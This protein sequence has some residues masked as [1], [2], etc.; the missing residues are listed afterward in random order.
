MRP[1]PHPVPNDTARTQPA[2]LGPGDVLTRLR[3]HARGP[4][5]II[6]PFKVPQEEA[7]E[8]AKVLDDLGFPAI[9]LASTDYESFET[10]MNPYIAAIKE[11]SNLPVLLHFPPRK[12]AG[13]PL[14]RGADAVMLP[15]LL[16]SRD[17]YYVWKS[18][19]ETVAAL[20][21]RAD[22][23]RWPELLLTVALTFGEDHKTGDLLGTVPVAT[24]GTEQIDRHIA[25]TRSFGF[26][27]VY[28]YSRYA[29]VPAE[30]VRHFRDRLDPGQILF[31]SG[32]VRRRD[33]VDAYLEAGADYVGFAGALEHLDWRST[34]T[35]MAGAAR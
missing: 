10:R 20:P 26:H 31:V 34:L 18:Y 11:V 28:L 14:A 2:L 32:N 15:A 6:D 29:R 19:L 30:V 9:I 5:H 12:G 33:H 4:V 22:R 25:V 3:G 8:K 17:D 23:E 1:T 27:M 7:V 35:E 24:A 16:G 13:F 21:A